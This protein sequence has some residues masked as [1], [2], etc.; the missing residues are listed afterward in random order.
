MDVATTATVSMD[1]ANM[2]P[3]WNLTDFQ[4]SDAAEP[5]LA[6]HICAY[7][8]LFD[9]RIPWPRRN[10]DHD[11]IFES[12]DEDSSSAAKH[13]SR[14]PAELPN[15]WAVLLELRN[16][17][18]RAVKLEVAPGWQPTRPFR[19]GT[20]LVRSQTA[21]ERARE[22]IVKS[23]RFI[24]AGDDETTTTV[25]QVLE[26][27]C[28]NVRHRYLFTESGEGSRYWVHAVLQDLETAEI[29]CEGDVDRA[30]AV[31]STVWG[32]GG[33][34]DGDGDGD[35]KVTTMIRRGM[36]TEWTIRGKEKKGW[37]GTQYLD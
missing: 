34:G 10:S 12:D 7:S 1:L 9:G 33:D 37:F 19:E 18:G 4:E 11:P 22:S 23:V 30:E 20:V 14:I 3:H 5:I 21:D 28:H 31:L 32:R 13:T 25:Q 26:N 2:D 16:G 24:V 17:G 35:G 27:M 6:V 15:H 36:F 29:L 8:D